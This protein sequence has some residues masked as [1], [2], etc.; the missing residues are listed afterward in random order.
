M[1]KQGISATQLDLL[2]A[3]TSK[4]MTLV[5]S[6]ISK[7][8]DIPFGNSEY[9]IKQFIIE[10]ALTPA[11]KYR[12][13]G[14]QLFEL[15]KTLGNTYFELKETQIDIE[16]IQVQLENKYLPV[17]DKKRLQLSLNRK[18][19]NLQF[20]EKLIRDASRE[21]SIYIRELSAFKEISLQQFEHE[22]E[23]YFYKKIHRELEEL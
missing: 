13:I 17:P 21:I 16:E 19:F 2:T 9:Q 22:E 23:M 6:A 8:D 12:A 10:D 11:R 20:T 7:F 5:E 18:L 1:L 14:L 15:L 3:T 4:L